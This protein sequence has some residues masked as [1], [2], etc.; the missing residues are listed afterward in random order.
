MKNYFY[1]IDF[2]LLCTH[3]FCMVFLLIFCLVFGASVRP[4]V[5][6][7]NAFL[8]TTKSCSRNFLTLWGQ[9]FSTEKR[10]T[11][12]FSVKLFETKNFLKNKDSL[13][14]VFG[15]V[16][17]KNFDGKS[18]YSPPLYPNFV[19]TRKCCNSK[20][21]PYGTFRHSETRNFRRKNVIPPCL[22]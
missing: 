5:L 6:A 3:P 2:S 7:S 4:R 18:W 8:H 9:K 10:D 17:H 19:D 14:K 16:R 22:L 20:G 13:T 21:F 11:P 15:T 1:K 12:L